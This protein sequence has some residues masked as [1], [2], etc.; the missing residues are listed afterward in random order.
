VSPERRREVAA[1]FVDAFAS[2][3]AVA[4]TTL[5]TND[6]GMWSDGGGK[7]SAARR[8][9]LG[10]AEVLN[11]LNGLYRTA[12]NSGRASEITRQIAEVNHEPALLLRVSGRLEAVFVFTID[13][14]AVSHIRVIRNPDKLAFIDQQQLPVM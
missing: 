12:A 14:E 13:G 1:R 2:G 7:A 11:F 3:D 4:L 5:L 6:V 9:L 10:R 8:P